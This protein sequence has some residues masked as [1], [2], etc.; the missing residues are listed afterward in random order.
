MMTRDNLVEVI[1]RIISIN[2]NLTEES[3]LNL[4]N[5]SG[6][7]KVDI[8][9]A[10]GY[11]RSLPGS[12]VL[13]NSMP[14]TQSAQSVPAAAQQVINI[15]KPVSTISPPEAVISQSLNTTEQPSIKTVNTINVPIKV[16]SRSIPISSTTSV[17]I[18]K[19]EVAPQFA[20][21][22]VPYT[23]AVQQLNINQ[24][25][26]V[27][28]EYV[29]PAVAFPATQNINTAPNIKTQEPLQNANFNI[30]SSP[31]NNLEIENVSRPWGLILLNLALLIILIGLV[32]YLITYS[33]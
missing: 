21:K 25:K 4:L 17:T 32:V 30:Q 28:E 10:L 2:K 20:A 27:S 1:N 18:Q 9:Q 6:W 22:A 14:N 13:I 31:A 8:D 3:M 7:E 26:T 29:V 11:F 15:T 16:E 5:A 33:A 24:A 12:K 23:P 19:A